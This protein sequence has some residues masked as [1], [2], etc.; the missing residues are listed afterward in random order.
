M[1]AWNEKEAHFLFLKGRLD[2]CIEFYPTL[3]AG[4]T[5]RERK[6]YRTGLI[7]KVDGE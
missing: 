2:F 6:I 7:S 1:D 3:E 4:E 5:L